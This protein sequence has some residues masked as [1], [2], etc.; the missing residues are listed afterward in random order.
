MILSGKPPTAA[1]RHKLRLWRR[2]YSGSQSKFLEFDLSKSLRYYEISRYS[3]VGLVTIP[4]WRPLKLPK[5]HAK[6]NFLSPHQC[7]R[8]EDQGE[9]PHIKIFPS[10]SS[11]IPQS[12][13]RIIY[14][15]IFR[16]FSVKSKRLKRQW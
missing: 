11:G 10:L 16:F 7:L 4:E 8:G 5:I 1:L 9:G 15:K 13:S 2:A 12:S 14:L 6:N 3:T